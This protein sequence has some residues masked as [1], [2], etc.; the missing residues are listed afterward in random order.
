MSYVEYGY[1]ETDYLTLP[2]LGGFIVE[3]INE[4]VEFKI[5]LSLAF[6]EQV[7]RTAALIKEINEQIDRQT[8]SFDLV[9]EQVLNQITET[10]NYLEQVDRNTNVSD[11]RY[12]QM[13]R[14][15]LLSAKRAREEVTRGKLLHRYTEKYLTERYLTEAYLGEWME[16][17]IGEQIDRLN[18]VKK[19]YNEEVERKISTTKSV[20]EQIQRKI[21]RLKNI[22]EQINLVRAYSINEQ[23]TL[24]LYNDTNLRILADFPSRGSDGLNWTASSTQAGDYS[25]NNLNTDIVEQIWR[26]ATGTTSGIILT[27]DTD[28]T[29]GV[30]VDTLAILNHNMTTSASIVWQGSNDPSFGTIGQSITLINQRNNTYYISPTLPTSSFRYWRFLISDPTNTNGFISIGTIVFGSSIIM[31]Q[32]CIVDE[33]TRGT[34]HFS[35]KVPTEAFTNVSNDRAIKYSTGIQMRNIKYNNGDYQRLRSVFDEARTSLKCL[36]IPTPK[37]PDRFAVFGKMSNIPNERHKV[38]SSD[39]DYIDF[40]VEVDESL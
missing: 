21:T 11:H 29:Q 8:S 39:G 15:I 12:E 19:H 32:T 4:Q 13:N 22:H 9:Y 16:I 5:N 37:F 1:L 33:V 40:T 36:W 6:N 27:C 7:D 26:S 38:I 20:R 14:Q 23:V 10:N 2:Y 30:F 24:V 3:N 35:D 25:V 28:V 31:Q 18:K 34:K 17:V